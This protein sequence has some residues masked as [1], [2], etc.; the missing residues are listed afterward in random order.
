MINLVRIE[1]VV[2]IRKERYPGHNRRGR[3]DHLSWH[4][5]RQQ[6]P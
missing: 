4:Y 1:T 5:A 6:W 2:P 3:P